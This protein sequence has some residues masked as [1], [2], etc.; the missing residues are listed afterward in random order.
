[1]QNP[2]QS[3]TRRF[4]DVPEEELKQAITDMC[5]RLGIS[6]SSF[7]YNLIAS[8]VLIQRD[9]KQLEKQQKRALSK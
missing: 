3:P 6:T 5:S 4:I 2:T 1:M 9:V 8:I 7:G